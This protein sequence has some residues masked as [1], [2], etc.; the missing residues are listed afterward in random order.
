MASHDAT[1]FA[2]GLW[3][4][5][6]ALSLDDTTF[7]ID[8]IRSLL[9]PE[10]KIRSICSNPEAYNANALEAILLLHRYSLLRSPA[11]IARGSL[12]LLNCIS[13][14]TEPGYA[15][16]FFVLASYS[17]DL[18]ERTTQIEHLNRAVALLEYFHES[19]KAGS[20]THTMAAL[21]CSGACMQY[22]LKASEIQARDSAL[23]LLEGVQEKSSALEWFSPRTRT[24]VTISDVMRY[25]YEVFGPQEELDQCL[26]TM[27]TILDIIFVSES[28]QFTSL[29]ILVICVVYALSKDVNL[30][31]WLECLHA[32]HQAVSIQHSIQPSETF[33]NPPSEDCVELLTRVID[34]CSISFAYKTLCLTYISDMLDTGGYSPSVENPEEVEATSETWAMEWNKSLLFLTQTVQHLNSGTNIRNNVQQ[35]PFQPFWANGKCED[36]PT[37]GRQRFRGLDLEGSHT[38]VF[39]LTIMHVSHDAGINEG[40]TEDLTHATFCRHFQNLCRNLSPE[41]LDSLINQPTELEQFFGRSKRLKGLGHPLAKWKK[42][43]AI[44]AY[45]MFLRAGK[46]SGQLKQAAEYLR[47]VTLDSEPGYSHFFY[48]LGADLRDFERDSA[49]IGLS[50]RLIKEFLR[51][52]DRGSAKHFLGMVELSSTLTIDFLNKQARLPSFA[53]ALELFREAVNSRTTESWVANA[54]KVVVLGRILHN[55]YRYFAESEECLERTVNDFATLWDIL[56]VASPYRASTLEVILISALLYLSAG[57]DG[58][59][60]SKALKYLRFGVNLYLDGKEPEEASFDR[61]DA[62]SVA[63]HL[64]SGGLDLLTSSTFASQ[65]ICLLHLGDMLRTIAMDICSKP[66]FL[67]LSLKCYERSLKVYREG[68]PSREAQ[69]FLLSSWVKEKAGIRRAILSLANPDRSAQTSGCGPVSLS[70]FE[71]RAVYMTVDNTPRSYN[72]A[73]IL[74]YYPTWATSYLLEQESDSASTDSSST[75]SSFPPWPDDLMSLPTSSPG[76]IQERPNLPSTIVPGFEKVVRDEGHEVFRMPLEL[77]TIRAFM[78]SIDSEIRG[79]EK[80]TSYLSEGLVHQASKV[81]YWDP[82]DVQLGTRMAHLKAQS[83]YLARMAPLQALLSR[84]PEQCLELVESSRTLFWNRL[85]R[86]QTSFAGLPDDLAS[87]L[88]AAAQELDKCKSQFTASVSKEEL[89]WQY[90]LESIF[91]QLLSKA[92]NVPGFENL[93]MPKNHEMLIEASSAG[94][95]IVLLGIHSTYAA[96]IVRP[97]GVD[98]VFLPDLTDEAI[99]KLVVGLNRASQSARSILQDQLEGGESEV[100]SARYG[101]P[102]KSP[103]MPSYETFLDAMW[104]LI[105]K[106][107][108]EF[109]GL[110]ENP[111]PTDERRRLWWCPTGRFAFLP[112]HAAGNNFGKESVESVS[113]YVVSSYIPTLSALLTAQKKTKERPI[114]VSD[115]TALVLAQPKTPGYTNLPMTVKEIELVETL[116][117]SSSLLHINEGPLSQSNIN[118]TVE[119]ATKHLPKAS[120]LHLACH[121]HQD[122][123]DP[124]NSGFELSDGRLSLSNLIACRNPNAF[125]AYLSACESA[126][127]DVDVPDESLNLAAAMLFAGFR[128]VIGTMW[129]MND[130][131]GPEVAR[132]IYEELFKNSD[133]VLDA[134]LIPY[135]LDSA[136]RKLQRKGIHASRWAT[137]IHVGM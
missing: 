135:A 18:F 75:N 118:R 4:E 98:S 96:L 67:R 6:K 56:P 68:N 35:E 33:V 116:I 127:N 132:S 84:G 89:Q 119:E 131:D 77:R 1:S 54:R 23:G 93:L 74:H 36:R 111:K 80:L 66:G 121:G 123:A 42:S 114:L 38:C 58:S 115:L 21:V 64:L 70:I 99:E 62:A 53:V 101:R 120:I 124:L 107:V 65:A 90:E 87:S 112:I 55:R 34:G 71:Y 44:V 27:K 45:L 40:T 30:R 25:R 37:L 76:T 110:L 81:V 100:N 95:I 133:Y 59:Y 72:H 28:H 109:M 97:S 31:S 3:A 106:P 129:T 13:L 32:L 29:Q 52:Q 57:L 117:P 125:L 130:N 46:R 50:S 60:W 16:F 92:R 126:A 69:A 10:G 47:S 22:Y 5:I 51:V 88:E 78:R 137:Y 134:N 73:C 104:K 14:A 128:S 136:V 91:N 26:K 41:Q 9:Q 43:P 61:N 20:N 17:L 108:F 15:Y 113:K 12:V 102:R 86:L 105:V 7:C 85:L 2:T 11:D 83:P 103:Q 49:A 48:Q 94:P 122:R 24:L 39:K 63:E 82:K 79:L 8:N 19:Q